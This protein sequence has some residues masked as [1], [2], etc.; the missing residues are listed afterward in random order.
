MARDERRA[1]IRV[2]LFVIGAL[3]LFV[4]GLFWIA[5]T[6]AW[7][8]G[9]VVYLVSLRDSG[10]VQAGDRVRVAG[11]PAGKIRRVELRPGDE[12]PVRFDV[13]LRADVPLHTDAVARITSAGLLGAAFLEIDPGTARLPVLPAGAEIRGQE[14]IGMDDAMARIDDLGERV[15]KLLDQTSSLLDAIAVDLDQALEGAN[16]L[17]SGQNV[18]NVTALLSKLNRAVDEFGPQLGSLVS[19]LDSVAAKADR[20]LDALPDL[21]RRLDGL[22]GDLRTAIGPDGERLRS[23]LERAD[24]SLGS[25][26]DALSVLGDNRHE[27]GDALRD[28][29]D[30]AANLK[31]FSQTIKERPYS[32]VRMSAP[33]QRAPGQGAR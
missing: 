31:A 3:G 13:S 30:T 16:R 27:L 18:D 6:G 20:E 5:G 1:D 12:R 24:A 7:G 8:D 10:G 32:L 4:S 28:L 9:R 2:G 33:P 25:A 15:A 17:M 26:D 29:R 11:V 21:A 22:A 19:R 23:L 14:T